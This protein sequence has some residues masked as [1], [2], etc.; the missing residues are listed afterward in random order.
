VVVEE[1]GRYCEMGD[2]K[3]LYLIAKNME[4]LVFGEF[5]KEL[6]VYIKVKDANGI[7]NRKSREDGSHRILEDKNCLYFINKKSYQFF[8]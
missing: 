8:G 5:V 3:L 2:W 6:F 4:P 7:N 1:I